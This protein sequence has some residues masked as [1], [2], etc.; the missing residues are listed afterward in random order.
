MAERNASVGYLAI[1]KE[2]TKGT[3]V[4][5]AVFAPYYKQSL[6]TDFSLISD[7]PVYG[8]KFKRFQALQGIR[9]HGGSATVMAEPNSAAYF[10]DMIST[11]LSTSGSN[12]YTHSF[13]ASSTTDPNS[14]TVDVSLV[15]QVVRFMGV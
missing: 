4:T 1:S 8:N 2:T 6:V 13:G 14:Y 11:K 15:S 5:P 3:A 12:P 7:E 10:L 9:S